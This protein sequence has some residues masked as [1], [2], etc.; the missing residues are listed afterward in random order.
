VLQVL[1]WLLI[2]QFLN[3]F[4]SRVL[5]ARGQQGRSL[6]VSAFGMAS[7]LAAAL[8]LI[9]QYG[10]IGAAW[11]SVIS[12]YTALVCYIYYCS[13]GTNRR[14]IASILLRLVAAAV[15]LCIAL[16][17]MRD[18]QL[19]AVLATGAVLYATL[20]IALRIV[21]TNDFKLFQELR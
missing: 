13:A 1:A 15:V 3:Q 7:F 5:Y 14:P 19:V 12:S 6:A 20:L 4:L 8:Y 2:P 9:P 17:L 10:V 11:S 21:S 18:T 16:R